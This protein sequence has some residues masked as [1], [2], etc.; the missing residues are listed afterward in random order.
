MLLETLPNSLITLYIR[1]QMD[2]N[3]IVVKSLNRL[4]NL[5]KLILDGCIVDLNGIELN[6]CSYLSLLDTKITDD[7]MKTISTIKSLK[8]LYF[9]E[10]FNNL[11]AIE[12]LPK[13]VEIKHDL[14]EYIKYYDEGKQK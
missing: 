4:N 2:E 7:D 1:Y 13:T 5:N 10:Y 14:M 6:N 11:P 3:D 12:T 8:K 9:S